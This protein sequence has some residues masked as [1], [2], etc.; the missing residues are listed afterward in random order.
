MFSHVGGAL[1]P[2]SIGGVDYDWRIDGYRHA[3][4]QI[5]TLTYG[6]TGPE[7]T[8]VRVHSACVTGDVFGALIEVT[9]TA[10][11]LVLAGVVSWR[12]SL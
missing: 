10:T 9:T 4:E 6:A 5:L 1:L 11:L 3:D 7:P 12:G 2:I 8:L